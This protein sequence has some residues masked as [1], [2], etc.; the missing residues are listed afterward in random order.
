MHQ[1]IENNWLKI[2]IVDSSNWIWVAVSSKDLELSWNG[3]NEPTQVGHCLKENRLEKRIRINRNWESFLHTGLVFIYVEPT[4]S[5]HTNIDLHFTCARIIILNILIFYCKRNMSL[6]DC[7]DLS[8][9]S[10]VN[11]IVGWVCNITN[12]I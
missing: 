11:W 2:N 8:S 10:N 7:T 12:H 4:T 5:K 9:Q 1:F 6:M 3:N